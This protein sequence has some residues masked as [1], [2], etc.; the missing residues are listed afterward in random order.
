MLEVH[1]WKDLKEMIDEKEELFIVLGRIS[2]QLN[3]LNIKQLQIKLDAE[4][5]ANPSTSMALAKLSPQNTSGAYMTITMLGA[6]RLVGLL[7]DYQ[8]DTR[9]DGIYVSKRFEE[10][11]SY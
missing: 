3:Q 5:L 11:A 6:E 4:G 10:V 1:S 7:R 9:M 8:I 2:K